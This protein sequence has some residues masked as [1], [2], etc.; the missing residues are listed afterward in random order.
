M[1][2][3]IL[4]LFIMFVF[5]AWYITQYVAGEQQQFLLYENTQRTGNG[6]NMDLNLNLILKEGIVSSE[7]N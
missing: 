4:L 2:T 7:S 6:V 3:V 1:T 5:K